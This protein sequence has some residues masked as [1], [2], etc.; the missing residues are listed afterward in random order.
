MMLDDDM[1]A[2]SPT[3]VYRVL[4]AAGRMG[5]FAGKPWQKGKGFTQPLKRIPHCEYR[6]DFAF[7]ARDLVLIRTTIPPHAARYTARGVR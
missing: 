4:K 6:E 2:V 5:R 3:S 1:V 7:L